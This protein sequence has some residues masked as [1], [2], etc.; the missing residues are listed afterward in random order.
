MFQA[1]EENKVGN[2]GKI[3]LFDEDDDGNVDL[4][5]NEKF[6]QRFEHNEV[7]ECVCV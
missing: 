3:S 1:G 6:K 7:T 4:K 2:T 5:V